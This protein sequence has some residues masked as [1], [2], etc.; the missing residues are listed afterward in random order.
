MGRNHK[1]SNK[2]KRTALS[3][4]NILEYR[5]E[6]CA[7]VVKRNRT[8]KSNVLKTNPDTLTKPIFMPMKKDQK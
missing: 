7:Q 6:L 2:Q 1:R 3:P 4:R 5:A 8:H